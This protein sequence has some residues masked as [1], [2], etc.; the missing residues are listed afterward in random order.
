M[1]NASKRVTGALVAQRQERAAEAWLG[2]GARSDA[3]RH[4]KRLDSSS[5]RNSGLGGSG[6]PSGGGL[7]REPSRGGDEAGLQLPTQSSAPGL[8]AGDRVG[9]VSPSVSTL[10]EPDGDR[11]TDRER[12]K[13]CG[14]Q[15]KQVGRHAADQGREAGR[16]PGGSQRAGG[17]AGSGSGAAGGGVASSLPGI[18]AETAA[19]ATHSTGRG[20]AGRW[21]AALGAARAEAGTGGGN[22]TAGG[23]GRGAVAVATAGTQPGGSPVEGVGHAPCG[24][25]ALAPVAGDG[26]RAGGS[27]GGS[28]PMGGC[29]TAQGPRDVR[30]GVD[31][32]AAGPASV[33][34]AVGVRGLWVEPGSRRRGVARRLLDAARCFTLHGYVA[35][36]RQVAFSAV[37]VGALA[38]EEEGAFGACAAACL[39]Q[40]GGAGEGAGKEGGGGGRGF[41]VL[42]YEDG[43]EGVGS[44]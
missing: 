16:Q 20:G 42:L 2:G 12:T 18:E 14:E 26:G 44:K 28:G 27:D 29:R 10:C 5:C 33:P 23:T 31:R 25:P 22:G 30:R 39:G 19:K 38:G 9:R 24:A 35:E 37:A 11:D 3:D 13:G 32:A 1:D 36:R 4:G 41:R 43:E 17:T 7:Q 34:V 8:H 15:G 40:R 21:C 6:L